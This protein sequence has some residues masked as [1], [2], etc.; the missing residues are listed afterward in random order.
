M[1]H[2]LSLRSVKVFIFHFVQFDSGK[3]IKHDT[4]ITLVLIQ[5]KEYTKAVKRVILL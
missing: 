1:R 5:I 3:H 2:Y 4:Y